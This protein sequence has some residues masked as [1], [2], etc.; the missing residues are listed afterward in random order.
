MNWL[1]DFLGIRQLRRHVDCIE[2]RVSKMAS[3]V[4]ALEA[5]IE[6]LKADV[7]ADIEQVDAKVEQLYDVVKQFT[8]DGITPEAAARLSK[9]IG[10]ARA[11]IKAALEKVATDDEPEGSVA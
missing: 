1:L 4:E 6:Q 8:N 3:T 9:K 11:P 10:E 2:E 7:T 5:E